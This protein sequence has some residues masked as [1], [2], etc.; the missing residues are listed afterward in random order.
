MPFAVIIIVYNKELNSSLTLKSLLRYTNSNLLNLFIINNGPNEFCLEDGFY[1]RIINSFATVNIE[2]QLD[3]KP[4]SKSYNDII[5]KNTGFSRYL[6]LDD[7]T[8]V[9]D[10]YLDYVVLSALDKYDVCVP[11]IRNQSGNIVYPIVNKMVVSSTHE[12]DEV[13][14]QHYIY[15][16]GS[17]LVISRKII[18]IFDNYGI[19][20][21][22]ERYA[23]YGVDISF[24]RRLHDFKKK[25]LLIKII[26]GTEIEHSL[27]SEEINI[28]TSRYK[29]R[30]IDLILSTLYYSRIGY[31]KYLKIIYFVFREI[32]KLNFQ[33]VLIILKTVI[34]G[35]HPRC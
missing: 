13:E 35:K 8:S 19:N 4:L 1:Q 11:R 28:S 3:N 31:G 21:F 15:T 26:V 32:Y 29:E 30:L 24:F 5:K 16:I 22:D 23:L 6:I 12:N 14:Q 2:K 18:E 10:E 34:N 17:G 27:S 20:L 33:N 9:S 25:G 7:D